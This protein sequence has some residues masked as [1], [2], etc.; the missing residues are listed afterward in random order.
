VDPT[1]HD[2]DGLPQSSA[3]VDRA[4]IADAE[5]ELARLRSGE[6]TGLEVWSSSLPAFRAALRARTH[7]IIEEARDATELAEREL[8]QAET[9]AAD[10]AERGNR[11]QIT[12]AENLRD[13]AFDFARM[14]DVYWQEREAWL[15]ATEEALGTLRPRELLHAIIHARGVP[16]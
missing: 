13:A 12:R 8:A 11:A 3:A 5:G 10:A 7:V 2:R 16:T 15:L 9:A 6:A 4:A 14:T 1:A